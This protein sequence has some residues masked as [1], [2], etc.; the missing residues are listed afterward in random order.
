MAVCVA[1]VAWNLLPDVL[2]YPF[3]WRMK[4]NLL[5]CLLNIER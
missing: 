3:N 2:E 1:E 5:A 4:C